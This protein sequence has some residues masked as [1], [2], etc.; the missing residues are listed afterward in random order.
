MT[1]DIDPKRLRLTE[2]GRKLVE[3]YTRLKPCPFCGKNGEE[4]KEE[5]GY[6]WT[7]NKKVGCRKC[8][9]SFYNNHDEGIEKWNRRVNE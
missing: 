7:F 1:G 4:W 2:A 3:K 6:P 8:G 9:I 5:G